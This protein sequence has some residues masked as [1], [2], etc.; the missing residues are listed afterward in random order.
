MGWFL[1]YYR[2]SSILA[3]VGF[4]KKEEDLQIN[5]FNKKDQ[6]KKKA[7]QLLAGL[8]KKPYNKVVNPMR[9][10]KEPLEEPPP[11]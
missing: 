11:E 8:R 9:F 1:Q 7:M 5:D 10:W 4:T 6:A 2:R 3:G